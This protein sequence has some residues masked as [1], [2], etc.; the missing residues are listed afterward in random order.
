MSARLGH[1]KWRPS[2]FVMNARGGA[3]QARDSLYDA[4]V[5]LRGP[6]LG[7]GL[8][9]EKS[10]VRLTAKF[11]SDSRTYNLSPLSKTGCGKTLER[12][13]SAAQALPASLESK[14]TEWRNQGLG[15]CSW[16]P[17]LALKGHPGTTTEF[18]RTLS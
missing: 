17:G 7:A 12:G 11:T 18:F 16:V 10:R 4:V 1:P 5:E 3:P 8:S 14:N 6:H 2:L 9:G 13:H 15:L